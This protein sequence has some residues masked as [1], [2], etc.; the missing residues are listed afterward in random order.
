MTK[1]RKYEIARSIASAVEYG[2]VGGVSSSNTIYAPEVAQFAEPGQGPYSF[3]MVDSLTG[4]MFRI[5]VDEI[6]P[7]GQS[8]PREIP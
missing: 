3:V 2:E 6:T 4:R 7:E 5:S 8:I 1:P